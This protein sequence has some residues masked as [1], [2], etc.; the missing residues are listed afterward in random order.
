VEDGRVV[1]AG[2]KATAGHLTYSVLD[3]Q[4][5]TQ[6]GEGETPR[7]PKDRFLVVQLAVTNTGNT[8]ASIPA[9]TLENDGGSTYNELTDG[10]GFQ[11]FLGVVRH[12]A[13]GQTERG[14]IAFDAP[15]AHYRLRFADETAVQ[16]I[17]ADLPLS[18]A[19]EKVNNAVVPATDMPDL[20][21]PTGAM[22]SPATK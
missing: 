19:H 1:P 11:N 2:E 18:Y 22:K 3:S 8:D 14:S 9:V 7:V 15:A 4:I 12:V 13:P 20:I 5:L 6:V 17:L 21:A 10:T 16:E